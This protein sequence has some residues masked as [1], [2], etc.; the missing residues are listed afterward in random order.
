MIIGAEPVCAAVS[1]LDRR[2]KLKAITCSFLAEKTMPYSLAPDLILYAKRMAEDLPALKGVHMSR[3]NCMYMTTHGV[4]KSMQEELCINLKNQAVSLNIDEATNNAGNK[5]L[6]VLARYWDVNLNQI[7]TNH[8]G[9]RI[10]NLAT[11]NNILLAVE[12]VL[13]VFKIKWT[14]IISCLMDNCS[15]MRGHKAGVET[16][17]RKKNTHL[18]DIDGDTAHIVSNAAKKFCSPFKNYLEN[19]A[20]S[21]FIDI[22]QQPKQKALFSEIHEI[23]GI[24]SPSSLIRPISSRFLQMRTVADRLH[25][26]IDT[27]RAYYYAHLEEDEKTT[28]R[29]STID[30]YLY[31]I[32][33]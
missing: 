20:N 21:V 9:S 29:Y 24:T 26:V 14:Q 2:T 1:L 11:A 31:I 19:F 23:L 6:N 4:A 30:E 16:L 10:V 12:D 28:H 13:D 5:V 33:N 22:Q 25:A 18:L 32:S 27:L 7:V 8:L 3:V 15:T 17:M